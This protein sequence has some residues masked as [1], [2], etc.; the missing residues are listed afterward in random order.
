MI[1][2]KLDQLQVTDVTSI[3]IAKVKSDRYAKKRWRLSSSCM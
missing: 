1:A 2:G 3:N